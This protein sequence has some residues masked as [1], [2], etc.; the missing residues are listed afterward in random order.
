MTRGKRTSD[1]TKAYIQWLAL[2]DTNLSTHDIEDIIKWTEY[3]C[4]HDTISR[5]IEE[6]RQLATKERWRIQLN[7]LE[8]I[9]D[10]IEEVTSKVLTSIKGK[11]DLTIRDIKDLTDISKTNWERL[12]MLQWKPTDRIAIEDYSK[13]SPKELEEERSKFLD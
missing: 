13:L 7:R 9:V 5:I 12:R 1:E 10:W 2:N 11:E 8:S 3:E 4:S 6:L